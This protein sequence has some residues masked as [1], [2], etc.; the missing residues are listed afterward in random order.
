MKFAVDKGPCGP[1]SVWAKVLW[2]Q[3]CVGKG[4]VGTGLCVDKGPVG[5]GLCGQRSCGHRSVWAKV[6][7]AQVCVGK[8]PVGTGLCGQRSCGQ[9]SVHHTGESTHDLVHTRLCNNVKSNNRARSHQRRHRGNREAMADRLLQTGIFS[10][11]S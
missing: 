5:T 9:T 2:A 7:W 3:V 11:F 8:G 10:A 6:L 4:P 1:R